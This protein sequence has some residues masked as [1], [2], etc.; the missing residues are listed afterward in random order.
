MFDINSISWWAEGEAK[1]L[2]KEKIQVQLKDPSQNLVIDWRVAKRDNLS[3]GR[4]FDI[5]ANDKPV[6]DF[7]EADEH[8]VIPASYLKAGENTINLEFESPISTSGSAVTRYLDKEDG[9]EYIYTLFVPS[10]ASTAFPCFDQPDL[11]ARFKLTVNTEADWK[12]ISNTTGRIGRFYDAGDKG[13]INYVF[14]ETE[15]ISTYLF[16]FAA[17]PFAEL[18]DEGSP[19]NTHVFVR[20][21][22]LERARPEAPDVFHL[23]RECISYFEKY[24]DF[25]FPFPKYDLVL[26]PEIRLWRN[27]TCG[28][29]FP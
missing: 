15:P 7:R 23:T 10:D 11:K 22:K 16:A 25:N 28:C 1:L 20:H 21:S 26:I 14:E 29:N 24:F 19:K 4:V 5:V 6:G 8:L 13:P 27:G 3:Q 17:G 12:V 9:S 2:G 18:K